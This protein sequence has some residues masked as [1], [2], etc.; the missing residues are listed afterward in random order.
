MISD[1][2]LNDLTIML[3]MSSEINS[4]GI[5]DWFIDSDDEKY[6][7]II[8]KRAMCTFKELINSY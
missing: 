8:V 4:V 5:I 3:K 1:E 6:L 2:S 7:I